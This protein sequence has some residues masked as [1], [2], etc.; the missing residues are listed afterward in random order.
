M[1]TEFEKENY[2]ANLYEGKLYAEELCVSLEQVALAEYQEDTDLH[3]AALFD[4]ADHQVLYSFR[5]HE[6][7]YPASVTKIMTALL[8]LERGNLEDQVT[9]SS[10]AAAAAFPPDASLCGLIEGDVWSLND[11]VN[12]LM[13]R[14]GNDA[15][16]AIAEYIAGSEDA[17]VAMMNQRA[18]E[19]MAN[20]THFM[21]PHGLHDDAHY[22]TAYDIYL[23]FKECIKD[24]RFIEIIKKD[25][26]TAS[27]VK[28]DGSPGSSEFSPTNYYA[29]GLADRPGNV[30]IVGGKT[31]T[32]GEAGNCLVL[33][34]Q[35]EDGDSYIS[36][37]MGA[38][39]KAV[40][41]TDMTSLILAI[42]D[43]APADEAGS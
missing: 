40:L 35:G 7:L 30:T 22:T 38:P 4:L 41:Y 19:L 42:P 11:L 13:I 25:S 33:L 39:D 14:S 26:F 37:V 27:Y 8:A 5:V 2:N 15:A 36:I 17:F 32:T 6:K 20:N 16:T 12:A 10:H 18:E 31:G 9:I 24:E 1:V 21:N 43:D 34:E 23:I 28:S 29:R 3:A